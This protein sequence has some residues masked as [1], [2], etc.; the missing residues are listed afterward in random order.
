MFSYKKCKRRKDLTYVILN[1]GRIILGLLILYTNIIILGFYL[2]Y[3]ISLNL[4][5]IKKF[6]CQ[7]CYYTFQ[8][9]FNDISEYFEKCGNIFNKRQKQIFPLYLFD[10]FFPVII[11]I[12]YLIFHIN[13]LSQRP[14]IIYEFT[15]YLQIFSIFILISIYLVITL[16]ALKRLNHKHCSVCLCRKYC[17]IAQNKWNVKRFEKMRAEKEED[18]TELT[19]L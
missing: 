18:R 13:N 7:K 11:G 19:C 1:I 15:S 2:I 9:E 4:F 8:D 16:I 10:W 14:E 17:S 6:L 3:T 12:I 5:F